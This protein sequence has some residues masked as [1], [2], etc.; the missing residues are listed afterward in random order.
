[1]V[2]DGRLVVA[3][4][5]TVA[6]ILPCAARITA[7]CILVFRA[8]KSLS[9]VMDVLEPDVLNVYFSNSIEDVCAATSVARSVLNFAFAVEIPR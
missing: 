5:S 3:S 8:A 9:P 7:L 6:D 2:S 4:A 1:M